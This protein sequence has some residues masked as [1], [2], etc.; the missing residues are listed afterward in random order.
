MYLKHGQSVCN[1]STHVDVAD[2]AYCISPHLNRKIRILF[3]NTRQK[4]NLVRVS[5]D[6]LSFFFLTIFSLDFEGGAFQTMVY[7]S[8]CY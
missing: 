5:K 6:V 2:N 8:V 1:H 4:R 7:E 3:P